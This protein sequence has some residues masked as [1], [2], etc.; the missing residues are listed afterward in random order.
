MAIPKKTSRI[1]RIKGVQYRWTVS[2]QTFD[3]GTVLLTFL[4]HVERPSDADRR[5]PQS[6]LEVIFDEVHCASVTPDVAESLILGARA[7]GWDPSGREN[8]IV[9]DPG[10]AIEL[11]CYS[12]G[13]WRPQV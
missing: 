1:T 2:R 13:A 8:F 11:L 5:S 4:A 12:M 3:S 7:I 10:A 9:S 6:K